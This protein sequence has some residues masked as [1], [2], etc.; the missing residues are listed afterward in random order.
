MV[1]TFFGHRDSPQEIK[2]D[3]SA[4][5]SELIEIYDVDTFYVG[6][7][8]NFDRMVREVLMSLRS[9]YSHIKYAVVLSYLP[10]E[11][12]ALGLEDYFD[13]IY[14]EGLENVPPKFAISARN[15]WL[16]EHSHI[17]VT[18]VKYSWGGAAQFKKLAEKRG[19]TVI[20]LFRN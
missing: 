1:C 20:N 18:Y 2:A 13:T 7:Q 4:T 19:K 3:L 15:R 14:P 10:N 8:G 5:I 11:K 12:K 17:V 16:V 6:N 9:K